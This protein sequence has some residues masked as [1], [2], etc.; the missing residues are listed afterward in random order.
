MTKGWKRESKRHSLAAR[1][2]ETTSSR[3][4]SAT[5]NSRSLE[6]DRFAS[7]M[8]ETSYGKYKEGSPV[9][10][11]TVKS[12][13]IPSYTH[14]FFDISDLNKVSRAIVD[15]HRYCYGDKVSD[16]VFTVKYKEKSKPA[17]YQRFY[18]IGSSGFAEAAKIAEAAIRERSK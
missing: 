12:K 14:T 11:I 8:H 5:M 1:G 9:I 13:G 3:S 2:V 16:V 15:W 6:A 17:I 4:I 10:R 7:V 18:S